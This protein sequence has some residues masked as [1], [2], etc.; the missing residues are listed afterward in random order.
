MTTFD[1]QFSGSGKR[2]G[3][4]T[5]LLE[6]PRHFW[7]NVFRIF[8]EAAKRLLDSLVTSRGHVPH[9]WSSVFA[10]R[11]NCRPHIRLSLPSG[12]SKRQWDFHQRLLQIVSQLFTE[13]GQV[14]IV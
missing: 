8:F 10:W 13:L 7:A 12:I 3:L 5:N 6:R 9:R 14:T 4:V 1:S 2:V 11:S